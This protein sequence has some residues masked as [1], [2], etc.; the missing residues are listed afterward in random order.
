VNITH[1]A[2]QLFGIARNCFTENINAA[3][4]AHDTA[5]FNLNRGLLAFLEAVER[6]LSDIR[7]DV[8]RIP[9]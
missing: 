1:S 8:G 6:E 5:S 2:S 9:R 3:S 7:S 4:Q